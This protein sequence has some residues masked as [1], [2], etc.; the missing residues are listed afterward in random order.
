MRLQCCLAKYREMQRN[1]KKCKEMQR[2]AE[3]CREMQRKAE[4]CIRYSEKCR[5]LLQKCREMKRNVWKCRG[6]QRNSMK[7]REMQICI[8]ILM[9][10][11]TFMTFYMTFMARSW[12][13][14]AGHML[15]I[16]TKV[17]NLIKKGQDHRLPKRF[18][19]PRL[20]VEISFTKRQY[21]FDQFIHTYFRNYL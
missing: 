14:D 10:F 9:T 13:M 7:Y 2:N 11:M 15:L 6:M 5:E 17:I 12:V 1:A 21:N 20:H 3:K 4:K 19:F 18:I 16:Q 8:D